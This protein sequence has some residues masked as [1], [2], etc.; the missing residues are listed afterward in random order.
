MGFM[1]KRDK[2]IIDLQSFYMAKEYVEPF[3]NSLA[4]C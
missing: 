4:A 3:V 1:H 2:H